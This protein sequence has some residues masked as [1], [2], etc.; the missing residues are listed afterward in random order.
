VHRN[1]GGSIG[2]EQ[3]YGQQEF[4]KRYPNH[5]PMPS[6]EYGLSPTSPA[7]RLKIGH[8][9]EEVVDEDDEVEDVTPVPPH[10][11][12]QRAQ[13]IVSSQSLHSTSS[14]P[15]VTKPTQ[16]RSEFQDTDDNLNPRRKRNPRR[17][18]TNGARNSR[19]AS[20]FNVPPVK[21]GSLSRDGSI[22]YPDNGPV[23][24]SRTASPPI[25]RYEQG[26]NYTSEYRER[27]QVHNARVTSQHFTSK[28]RINENTDADVQLLDEGRGGLHTVKALSEHRPAHSFELKNDPVEGS[29]DELAQP[30]AHPLELRRGKTVKTPAQVRKVGKKSTKTA[31]RYFELRSART[32]EF[33][34]CGPHLSLRQD[35]NDLK[36]FR[37]TGLD[38]RDYVNTLRSFTLDKV[39]HIESDNST[40]MRLLGPLTDG[41]RC[42]YDFEFSNSPDFIEFRDKHIYPE[43]LQKKIKPQ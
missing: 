13:S 34:L 14:R 38:D 3:H 4:L 37:I 23:Q 33:E 28:M 15:S 27:P 20:P 26:V 41:I 21:V 9:V 42:W 7:K 10:A 19:N 25:D 31:A 5:K 22:E 35:I 24:L 43:V 11:P 8:A 18:V 32:Y 1:P 12:I 30:L 40:R 16:P 39:T 36:A 2:Y 29:E 17:K 6:T